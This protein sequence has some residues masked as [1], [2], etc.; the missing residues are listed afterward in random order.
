MDLGKARF[1]FEE[2]GLAFPRL[3]EN[4]A[5][6][7]KGYGTWHYA[8]RQV[9]VRPYNLGPFIDQALKPR[10][11]DY[12]LL[13]HD[14]HGVNSY[15]IHYYLA[16]GPLRL[17]LQ[18][19]WGG[20]YMERDAASRQIKDCFALADELVVESDV[21]PK[22]RPMIIVASE[23]SGCCWSPLL[24]TFDRQLPDKRQPGEVL[25][26]ALDWLMRQ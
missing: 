8:T 10:I 17:L 24:E 18:L 14:G 15:A 4:L 12:A 16:C 25:T 2:A 21:I 7:L 23:F 22:T 26:E 3:P 11:A 5:N 20:V 19:G 1:L 9:K 6:R 13:A